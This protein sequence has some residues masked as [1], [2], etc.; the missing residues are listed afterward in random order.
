MTSRTPA[1]EA[2]TRRATDD[3]KAALEHYNI[4]TEDKRSNWRRFIG[5][6]NPYSAIHHTCTMAYRATME[7][8]AVADDDQCPPDVSGSLKQD[9]SRYV[10]F[11]FLTDNSRDWLTSGARKTLGDRLRRIILKRLVPSVEASDAAALSEATHLVDEQADYLKGL[12]HVSHLHPLD[13]S[14]LL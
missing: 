1:N 4:P 12:V 14:N 6:R 5:S 9:T 2:P 10:S 3:T 13:V 8:Q 11:F 7:A